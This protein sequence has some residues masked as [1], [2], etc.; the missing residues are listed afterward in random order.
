MQRIKKKE[1]G[2]SGDLGLRMAVAAAK[3]VRSSLPPPLRKPGVGGHQ[4]KK[5][6]PPCDEHFLNVAVQ[7]VDYMNGGDVPND[8]RVYT[9]T[10]LMRYD[11]GGMWLTTLPYANMHDDISR[12]T[13]IRG[14]MYGYLLKGV[15]GGHPNASEETE[16]LIREMISAED[17][18]AVSRTFEDKYTRTEGYT[19]LGTYS[20]VRWLQAALAREGADAREKYHELFAL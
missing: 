7:F 3:E 1:V 2:E 15:F 14:K 19:E 18:V 10:S 12:H 13:P 17:K 11:I 9:A 20:V 8:G 4:P 16:R 5:R 6:A